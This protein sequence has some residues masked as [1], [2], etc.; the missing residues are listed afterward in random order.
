MSGTAR[1]AAA[2]KFQGG[3]FD[4]DGVLVDSPHGRAWRD[5]LREL[6]ASEWRDIAD[7]TSYS[8]D[9]FTPAVCQQVIAG[10]PRLAG[11]RAALDYFGVPGAD[12]RAERYAAAKQELVIRLIEAGQ[13]EAFADALRFV[14]AVKSAGIP[15]AAASSSKNAGLLLSAI[16]M[17]T[18]AAQQGID[19][20]LAGPGRTLLGLFDADLSG[21]DL[22]RGK[23]DPLIFLTA[24][25]EL[26]ARPERCFVVEDASS[27]VRAARA[28][29]MAALRVA[30]L[31]D[32]QA[33]LDAGADLVVSSLD[34][35]SRDAL[36]EGRL[37]RAP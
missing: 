24:A 8:A 31:A 2:L 17:D 19:H 21:H 37:E 3:I 29:G 12:Q 22:A 23:P 18:F 28:G 32:E 11:A 7:R 36:A 4:V 27:G 14:L 26:G 6:M 10:L 33:L 34:E 16:R 1:T 5:A 9:R 30:R 20:P 35:V 13:F 25:Q 15:V